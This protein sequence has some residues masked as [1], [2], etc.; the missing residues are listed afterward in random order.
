MVNQAEQH[1]ITRIQ[2]AIKTYKKPDFREGGEYFEPAAVPVFQRLAKEAAQLIEAQGISQTC[3]PL[4]NLAAGLK[5]FG[6]QW[7]DM[8]WN[9]NSL[10]YAF[11]KALAK[12][13]DNKRNQNPFLRM[14]LG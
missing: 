13:G 3:E 2:N 6:E 12:T 11:E 8:G 4:A 1:L 14:K 9:H 5:Q 7:G 10:C